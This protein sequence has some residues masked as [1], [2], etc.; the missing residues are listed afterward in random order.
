MNCF[1][2]CVQQVLPSSFLAVTFFAPFGS[3]FLDNTVL[4]GCHKCKHN[5]QFKWS[6]STALRKAFRKLASVSAGALKMML[7]HIERMKNQPITLP[8][9]D[10]LFKTAGKQN[11]E[12]FRGIQDE[13]WSTFWPG[14]KPTIG[15]KQW[16]LLLACLYLHLEI[17]LPSPVPAEKML[18]ASRIYQKQKNKR[19][20]TQLKTSILNRT[21]LRMQLLLLR[22]PGQFPQTSVSTNKGNKHA[23]CAVKIQPY[24]LSY[25][26]GDAQHVLYP[27]HDKILTHKACWLQLTSWTLI[28]TV[29]LMATHWHVHTWTQRGHEQCG[30]QELQKPTHQGEARLPICKQTC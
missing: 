2:F 24:T 27:R 8:Q 7:K 3:C 9:C 26:I 10:F 4:S 20:I 19:P 14:H 6:A 13:T 30:A 12:P 22:G 16:K 21:A 1:S 15:K 17:P 29:T 5:K 23:A 25:L 11:R 18:D 28:A